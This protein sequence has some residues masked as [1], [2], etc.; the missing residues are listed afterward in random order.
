M[1]V[2]KYRLREFLFL[3]SPLLPRGWWVWAGGILCYLLVAAEDKQTGMAISALGELWS[4]TRAKRKGLGPNWKKMRR[5]GSRSTA[6]MQFRSL[7]IVLANVNAHQRHTKL[8]SRSFLF[9]AGIENIGQDQLWTLRD[10][11]QER[12]GVYS[13][14]WC[15]RLP[16]EQR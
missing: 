9:S 4:E 12:D 2:S 16:D 8:W 13:L 10:P 3:M 14:W 6:D 15:T 11:E 5:R 1:S 7:V